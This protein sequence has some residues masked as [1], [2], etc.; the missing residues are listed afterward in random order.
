M[1]TPLLFGSH[2]KKSFEDVWNCRSLIKQ[3]QPSRGYKIDAFWRFW[4]TE[5]AFTLS[6]L[7][8]PS[9]T[10]QKSHGTWPG[11]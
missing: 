9:L 1:D 8:A 7:E 2:T 3:I 6:A 4:S 10:K 11:G 5:K